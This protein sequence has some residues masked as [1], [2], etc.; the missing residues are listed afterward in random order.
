MK[1]LKTR[2]LTPKAQLFISIPLLIVLAFLV[3]SFALQA[4]T[5]A[6]LERDYEVV[7]DHALV[8]GGKF[9]STDITPRGFMFYVLDERMGEP[10]LYACYPEKV[11][12]ARRKLAEQQTPK[13]HGHRAEKDAD[14]R[15]F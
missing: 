8:F 15:L 3:V 14:Y 13:R 9:H 1:F 5:N 12:Q 2:T 7:R 11:E 6:S 10:I 4:T